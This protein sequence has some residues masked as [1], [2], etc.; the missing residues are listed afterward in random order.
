[1]T[2]ENLP[3]LYIKPTCP[4]CLEVMAFLDGNGISHREVN[5]Q[6]DPAG[7]DE[8]RRVSGQSRV[9]TLNWNGA[10]LS[11]F[12]VEELVPFLRERNVE[13]EDS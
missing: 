2:A 5:V 13:L 4:W 9:P 3:I 11:D 12:G 1:M 10:I 8:M 6:A 7:F